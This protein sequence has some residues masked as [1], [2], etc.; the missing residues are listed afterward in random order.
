MV[1]RA[2]LYGYSMEEPDSFMVLRF[3]FR[4]HTTMGC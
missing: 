2:L 4:V 3:G 1:R